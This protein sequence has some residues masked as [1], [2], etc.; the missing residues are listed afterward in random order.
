MFHDWDKVEEIQEEKPQ[1]ELHLPEIQNDEE[2]KAAEE[3][4]AKRIEEL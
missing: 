3:Q 4:I 2:A 1:V